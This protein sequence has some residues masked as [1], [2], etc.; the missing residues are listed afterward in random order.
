MDTI[1]Q[2]Q[3]DRRILAECPD[4]GETFALADAVMFYVGD[5]LPEEAKQWVCGFENDIKERQKELRE[6]R[7][8]V[9]EASERGATAVGL[10][11][12]L[13]KLVPVMKD[14]GADSRDVRP[15]FEPI[16]YVVFNG[17]AARDGEVDSLVFLDVKTGKAGL[18]A[19]QRQI[20]DAVQGGK[21]EWARYGGAL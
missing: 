3:A 20:R 8:K 4:S 11:K 1:K 15:L 14:F 10:G 2:L 9:K 6:R 13:E 19:S 5:P 18:Q 21:V 7:R 17:L 12:I 16:D